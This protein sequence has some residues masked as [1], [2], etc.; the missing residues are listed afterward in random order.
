LSDE[1][2][3]FL[4]NS[5]FFILGLLAVYFFL[6]KFNPNLRRGGSREI[7]ILDRYPLD[8][9]SSLILFRVRDTTFL[10]C[11]SRGE[12]KVLREWKDEESS[13]TSTSGGVSAD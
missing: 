2:F 13:D 8:R 7:E 5:L 6:A 3:K 9:E 10:C 1:V 11:Q 4:L 12:V